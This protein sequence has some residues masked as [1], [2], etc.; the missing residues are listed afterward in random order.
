M[1]INCQSTSSAACGR[2]GAASPKACAAYAAYAAY[3]AAPSVRLN[4]RNG[5]GL[6]GRPRG[7]GRCTCPSCTWST[8]AGEPSTNLFYDVQPATAKGPCSLDGIPWP[9]IPW[10]ARLK[11]SQNPLGTVSRPHSNDPAIGFAQR[12]R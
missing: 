3:A 2:S 5:C 12:L 6:P 11:R 7:S 9:S 4:V 1:S 10:S 8:A